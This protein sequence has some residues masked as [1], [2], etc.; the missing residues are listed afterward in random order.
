[1]NQNQLLTK[2]NYAEIGE[3]INHD[4]AAKMVKDYQDAR[5][6]DVPSFIIGKNVIE[7]VLAQPGCVG[8][9]FFNAIDA[10]TGKQTLVYAG[11]DEKGKVISEIPAIDGDG[12]LGQG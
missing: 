8:M 6:N 11:V 2:T 9:Q 5:P 12:K 10:E 1:M 4:L 3:A 7:Q